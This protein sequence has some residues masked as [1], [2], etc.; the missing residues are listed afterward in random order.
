MLKPNLFCL[1][2]STSQLDLPS[3]MG[4]LTL[5]KQQLSHTIV[6]SVTHLAELT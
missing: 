6:I 3:A 2:E 4:L 1:D 5:L